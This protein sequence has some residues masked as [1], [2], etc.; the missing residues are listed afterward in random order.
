VVQL[1]DARELFVK[2]RKSLGNKRKEISAGQIAEIT[3][4]YGAFVENEQVKI[5]PNES[6]GF[7]RITVERPLRLH[8]EVTEA[9]LPAI[10][11]SAG[12]TKLTEPERLELV[13][14]LAGLAGYSSI[15][16]TAVA[17]RIGPLSKAIEKAVWDAL[18]VRDIDTH[19]ETLAVH[20]VFGSM[21]LKL[22]AASRAGATGGSS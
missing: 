13:N 7:Q 21:P 10:E 15:D 16:R 17:R 19:K 2:M 18:A 6:F 1:V 4:L 20:Y 3:R 12:W 9:T 11:T 8:W 14:R 22:Q 5:L